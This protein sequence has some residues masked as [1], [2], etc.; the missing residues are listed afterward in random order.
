M[1]T[2]S[3]YGKNGSICILQVPLHMYNGHLPKKETIRPEIITAFEMENCIAAWT[4]Q[5]PQSVTDMD[6]SMHAY[7]VISRA[8]D[9]MV[10][11]LLWLNLIY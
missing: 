5:H 7:L 4:L 9:T 6:K 2:C 8:N 11:V 1:V 3:G 10:T